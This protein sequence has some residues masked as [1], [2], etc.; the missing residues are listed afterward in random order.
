MFRFENEHYLWGLL[1][2]PILV[3]IYL[4]IHIRTKKKFER[5]G[6]TSLLQKLMPQRSTAVQ[7]TK[8][9]LLMTALACFIIAI[10]NPQVGSSLEKGM[11]KGVDIMVCM[12]VSNSMLAED[13]KPNRL[14]A[15]NMAMS[16]FIDKLKGDRVG[17]VVFAG[18]AFTQLPI[19][20]D[21]AAA[22]M[23]INNVSTSMINMQGTDIAA[24]L[25]L[26]VTA[27]IPDEK[28]D[29]DA[30]TIDNLTSK[31]IIVVSDGEDHF[32]EAAKMAARIH[33]RDIVVHT[34]G[35]GS[36]RGEP[37]P[38]RKGATIDYKKDSKGNTVI[39]RLNEAALKTIA[40][41]GGGVYVHANNANMGF[42]SILDEINA[43]F[44]ADVQEITFARYD[45]K[46]QIPLILGL[47]L[48]LVELLLFGIKPRWTN[49][50][51]EKQMGRNVAFIVILFAISLFTNALSAQTKDELNAI[52]EGNRLFNSA[53]QLRDDAMKLKEE[54]GE[55]NTITAT[56]KMKEAADLY[57]KA[58]IQY[59]KSMET[60]KNWDK[61]N[62]NLGTSLYRQEQYSSAADAFKQVAERK[63][64]DDKLR[65]K[66]YH[67]M[68]NSYLKEEK[69]Q[70]SIDSYKNSLKLNPSDMDTKYNLEYAKK[71]LIQ[72]Q[73][74]Q[75][76]NQDQQNQNK[77]KQQQQNQQNKDQQNK[78]QQQ[79]NQDQQN[80][81]QQ[82]QQPQQGEEDKKKEEE[83]KRQ[84]SAADRQK[85]EMDKR[86]L[87]ALQQNE[88]KTQEKLQKQDERNGRPVK[89]EKDW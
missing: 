78:D 16:N 81:D 58:E 34:I 23:F 20:S 75:Q 89:Q 69:Y 12:D 3:V 45:S 21:Y 68:G 7:V 52:R 64:A 62:Y 82:N 28:T 35:I 13:I 85:Q 10:A 6:E 41:S 4:I 39:T 57:K 8:F 36:T 66:A 29:K 54:G 11:R 87:D 84:E 44:K 26:A 74:Q 18:K 33:E 55:L 56:E 1:I 14:E 40:E 51:K 5:Y 80:K 37:I 53:E 71:K 19:T 17:L 86:Q 32:D 61:A 25:D 88:R 24:A 47:I 76:Q 63:D 83:R 46:F 31:V 59:R 49:W 27:L 79:Q 67:N 72:Q 9:S 30:L 48:L 50:F 15:S 60:T 2:I 73:Q 65:A 22:K 42:E 43:M 70:E 38:V 77:D